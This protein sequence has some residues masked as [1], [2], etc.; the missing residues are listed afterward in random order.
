VLVVVLELALAV[1]Q[2]HALAKASTPVSS[3][4]TFQR[5]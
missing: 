1:G 3:A 2:A 4:E 5:R